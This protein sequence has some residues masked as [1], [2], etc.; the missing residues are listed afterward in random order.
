MYQ[1]NTVNLNHCVVGR[2]LHGVC[3]AANDLRMQSD[4]VQN[5]S[6]PRRRTNH[7]IER[8]EGARELISETGI[9]KVD[10]KVD[11]LYGLGGG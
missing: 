8:Q 9:L 4:S 5:A 6:W 3:H 10:D 1:P 7:G 11:W 2:F